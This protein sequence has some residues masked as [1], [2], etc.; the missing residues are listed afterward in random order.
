MS[1]ATHLVETFQLFIVDQPRRI[2]PHLIIPYRKPQVGVLNISRRRIITA[3]YEHP[4]SIELN[5]CGIEWEEQGLLKCKATLIL[6]GRKIELVY[7][8]PGELHYS[9]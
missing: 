7:T 9:Q 1:T 4:V 8:N 6:G 2:V 5:G 3:Q